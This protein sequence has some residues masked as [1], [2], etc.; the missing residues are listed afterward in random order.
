MKAKNKKILLV[1]KVEAFDLTNSQISQ[2]LK[3]NNVKIY[4]EGVLTRF[5]TY[6]AYF[7]IKPRHA[8]KVRQL[9]RKYPTSI[10]ISRFLS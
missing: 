3:D 10:S 7:Y 5:L 8:L 6:N 4:L 9:F 1:V 2:I